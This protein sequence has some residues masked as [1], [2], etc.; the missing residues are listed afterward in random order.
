[1]AQGEYA[2]ICEAQE[3]DN[4]A[5]A[6]N[7]VYFCSARVFAHPPPQRSAVTHTRRGG[8]GTPSW[9]PEQSAGAFQFKLRSKLEEVEC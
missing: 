1:M 9:E 7:C 6:L 3:E 8:G 5:A 4:C 2:S